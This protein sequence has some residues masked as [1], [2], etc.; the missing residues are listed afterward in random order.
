MAGF[1]VF[2][3]EQIAERRTALENLFKASGYRVHT[4]QASGNLLSEVKS[5]APDII[6]L[7]IDPPG[8]SSLGELKA[9]HD[10][11]P[12]IP[13][14]AQ[15]SNPSIEGAVD[16]M[17]RGAYNY[18]PKDMPVSKL[19][20]V[21]SR[22]LEKERLRLEVA[23]KEF[24][25]KVRT[26]DQPEV[27]EEV[28]KIVSAKGFKESS[29]IACLQD[30]QKE[31]NYLPYD[32]LRLVA[33]SVHVNLPRVYGIA[34]FYKSFS[35]RPR[36]R[37]LIHVCLGTACHVRGGARLLESFERELGIPTGGT[38]Y[39]NRFTLESVRCLGCCGLAPVV[40][41][42]NKFYGKVTQDKVRDL[43]DR[44]A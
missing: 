36:G 39:D 12:S 21:V 5:I 31:L 28:G 9:L 26:I 20:D 41:I 19:L 8:G 38:T 15:T 42:D 6:I 27:I 2:I 34:T 29:L 33:A 40:M 14:I 3:L 37:H 22:G 11:L 25:R 7:D 13:I 1:T 23:E 17:R 44:H 32:A 24:Q 43:I 18:I 35:L 30:I 4:G 16:A 10:F